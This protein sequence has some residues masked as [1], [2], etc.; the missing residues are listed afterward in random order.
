MTFLS[1]EIL[2]SLS[3]E[4]ETLLT[5]ACQ[6]SNLEIVKYLLSQ[7]NIDVNQSSISGTPLY[8]ASNKGQI[9]VILEIL[10]HPQIDINKGNSTTSP[11]Y[12]ACKNNNTEVV[13]TLLTCSSLPIDINA[14][15]S[16][17]YQACKNGNLEIVELLIQQPG[18]DVN[19]GP[20]DLENQSCENTEEGHI[21]RRITPLHAALEGE[22]FEIVTELMKCAGL[23]IVN[24]Y[25]FAESIGVGW[26]ID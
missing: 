18:L 23:D 9:D 2:K 15:E 3:K 26:C 12:I 20:I 19:L 14:G 11:L 1:D 4:Q 6:N 13:K 5:L 16:P 24:D 21:E 10:S 8:I 7:Q 17:L 22:F 25:D